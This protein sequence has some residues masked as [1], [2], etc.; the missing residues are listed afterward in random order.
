MHALPNAV[1]TIFLLSFCHSILM[2]LLF[3][4]CHSILTKYI[5]TN[6]EMFLL[7]FLHSLR[8]NVN[9]SNLVIEVAVR[10]VI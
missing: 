9:F 3:F 2:L 8:N 6:P 10:N 7:L 4:F 1:L 5:C